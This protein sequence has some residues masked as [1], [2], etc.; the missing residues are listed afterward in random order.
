MAA[1]KAGPMDIKLQISNLQVVVV[2]ADILVPVV[3][4]G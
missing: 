3:P 4:V 1:A 2:L